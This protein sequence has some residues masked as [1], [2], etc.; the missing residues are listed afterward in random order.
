VDEDFIDRVRIAAEAE[1]AGSPLPLDELAA[2]LEAGGHLG[3]PDEL[4]SD[5]SDVVDH[6]LLGTDD[7]WTCEHDLVA[8]TSMLLDGAVFTHRLTESEVARGVIDIVP[9]I[10][11]LDFDTTGGLPLATG[12]VLECRFPL[13]GDASADE[14]GSFTG[15]EGWLGSHRAGE[16]VALWRRDGE[17]S[18]SGVDGVGDGGAEER[19]LRAA[20]EAVRGEGVGV[21]PVELVLEAL[22]HDPGLFRSPVVPVGEL[23]ERIGLERSG[24]W[25]GPAGEDWQ[26]PG[27]R[28]VEGLVEAI[29]SEWRFDPC[30]DDA[31]DLVLEAWSDHVRGAGDWDRRAA[32]RALHH[33]S[34]APAFVDYVFGPVSGPSDLVRA[35]ATVLA[36]VPG[37][38]AA[39]GLFLRSVEAE[40]GG[41]TARAEADLLGAVLADGEYG[42]ALADLAWYAADRG[43]A[44]RAV[45]LLRRSGAGTDDPEVDFLSRFA[46]PDAATVGRNDPC[47]CGSGRKFKQCC[48]NGRAPGLDE[49]AEWL[50]HKMVNFVSRPPRRRLVE[51]LAELASPAGARVVELLL[52]ALFDLAVFEEALD[53]FLEERGGLLPVD[54]RDLAE[55]WGDARLA[56]WEVV[57]TAADGSVALRDTRTAERVTVTDHSGAAVLEAGEYLLARPLPVGPRWLFLGTPV[58]ITL[59]LRE[60]LIELL[61]TDPGAED[62]AAWLGA[63]FGPIRLANREGHQLAQCRAVLRPVAAPWEDVADALDRH[64]GGPAD[65]VWTSSVTIDGDTVVRAVVARH[66]DT[67]TVETNSRERLDD[68]VEELDG[69]LAGGLEILET[70]TVAAD[71]FLADVGLGGPAGAGD[72]PAMPPE[73]RAQLEELM[74][75]KEEAWL[76]ERVPALGGLTPREAADDP[77]RREDLEGLLR[78]FDRH[79]AEDAAGI[80]IGFD[81]TRLRDLLGLRRA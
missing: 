26:P 54:E 33:G 20:C 42:P 78:E 57:G 34:V 47:P 5:P 43:D 32:A 37:T 8:L 64:L 74:R 29:R 44:R 62:V 50:F 17:V 67:L 9:D 27:V 77:T 30:C 15:P 63:A 11:P 16:L 24:G 66:G 59:R 68:V 39:A 61:D 60:S 71:E 76:D 72:L 73:I 80:G 53:A 70:E 35:F 6:A 69:L 28:G 4:V 13:S 18:L 12:G 48:I 41:D 40:Y 36:R 7:T 25:F 21:E 79:R 45:S 58:R 14:N 2:R 10:T 46:A 56:L 38:A 55:R 3:D 52:P 31:F 19:A 75:A 65:G 49:R 22:C 51:D 23:L 1:L 81:A